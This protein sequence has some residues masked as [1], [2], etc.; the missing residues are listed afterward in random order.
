MKTS[1]FDRG[2][3]AIAAASFLILAATGRTQSTPAAPTASGHG[4]LHGGF[5]AYWNGVANASSYRL[6][7]ATDPGFANLVSGYANLTV[8]LGSRHDVTGLPCGVPYY[9]RVRAVNASGTSGNSNVAQADVAFLLASQTY[10]TPGTANYTTPAS[11]NRL[12]IKLWGAGGNAAD[13][14]EDPGDGGAG[15]FVLAAYGASAGQTVTFQVG[16]AAMGPVTPK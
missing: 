11:T 13:D 5:T 6:D 8:S 1:H 14:P 3:Q 4:T 7:V 15:G 12:V 9:Y 2:I 16:G 10:T